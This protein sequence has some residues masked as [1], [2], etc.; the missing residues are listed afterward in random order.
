MEQPFTLSNS[1]QVSSQAVVN[2]QNISADNAAAIDNINPLLARLT[3]GDEVAALEK[4]RQAYVDYLAV[5]A[6]LRQKI[7]AGNTTGAVELNTGTA[8]GSS[9]EAF[10]RFVSAIDE[11]RTVN[12]QVF[13]DI[14]NT[15]RE[16]LPRNQ[17]LY[18]LAGYLILMGLVVVGVVHRFREL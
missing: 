11:V 4:A 14:W 13:D 16:I 10:N 18:G 17:T 8:D 9:E 1:N 7:D 15:Q 5:D 2:A 3:Y 6:Q 12:Q